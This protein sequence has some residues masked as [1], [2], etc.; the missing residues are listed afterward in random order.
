[1]NEDLNVARGM[2]YGFLFSCLIWLAIL[3]VIL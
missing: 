1:M 2:V 3:E